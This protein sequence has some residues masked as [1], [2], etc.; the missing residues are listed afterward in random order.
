MRRLWPVRVANERMEIARVAWQRLTR[1][2]HE[3]ACDSALDEALAERCE[4]T[5]S[6]G[7]AQHLVGFVVVTHSK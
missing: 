1:R 2:E 5:G 6:A 7:R 4:E 3:F